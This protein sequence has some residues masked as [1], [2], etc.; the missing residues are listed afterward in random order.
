MEH[1]LSLAIFGIV[2]GSLIMASCGGGGGGS[3]ASAGGNVQTSRSGNY[4]QPIVLTTNR[5]IP[6]AC[7]DGVAILKVGNKEY[8]V[9]PIPQGNSSTNCLLDF[10]TIE[11]SSEKA[12]LRIEYQGYAPIEKVLNLKLENGIVKSDKGTL[13]IPLVGVAQGEVDADTLRSSS[14]RGFAIALTRTGK[15]KFYRGDRVYRALNDTQNT[16]TIVANEDPNATKVKYSLRK[17]DAKSEDLKV[18]PGEF[19]DTEGNT[20]RTGGFALTDLRDEKGNPLTLKTSRQNSTEC[21]W[22]VYMWLSSYDVSSIKKMKDEDPNLEGCQVPIYGWVPGSTGWEYLGYIT[23]VDKNG[24]KPAC[25]QLD[26]SADYKYEA[27]FC[28]NSPSLPSWCNIDQV[29]LEPGKKVCIKVTQNGKPLSIDGM[30]EAKN[31]FGYYPMPDYGTGIYQYP[32]DNPNSYNYYLRTGACELPIPKN[33]QENANECDYYTE[34]DIG[35]NLA[36]LTAAVNST[37]NREYEILLWDGCA[38]QIK[39]T[40]NHIAQFQVWKGKEISIGGWDRIELKKLVVNNSREV[41]YLNISNHSP[42]IYIHAPSKLKSNKAFKGQIWVYDPD[43]D[44]IEEIAVKLDGNIEDIQFKGSDSYKYAEFNLGNLTSG[45]HTLEVFA[46]DS[47]GKS[48]NKTVE[49]E[50]KENLPPK[51]SYVDIYQDKSGYIPEVKRVYKLK[52]GNFTVYTWAYDPDGEISQIRYSLSGGNCNENFHTAYCQL[53]TEGNYTLTIEVTDDEGAKDEKTLKLEVISGYP[54]KIEHIFIQNENTIFEA[55]KTYPTYVYVKDKDSERITLEVNPYSYSFNCGKVDKEFI[56]SGNLTIPE[57]VSG[58]IELT[59]KA[60]DE[61]GNSDISNYTLTIGEVNY[62]P[63]IVEFNAPANVKL[64]ETK[65]LKVV[66]Y[67]PDGD[68][69]TYKWYLDDEEIGN[70]PTINYTFNEEG[71]HSLEVEVS[72]GKVTVEREITVYVYRET[73]GQLKIKTGVPGQYVVIFDDNYNII[74]YA[75]TNA[76]GTATVDIDRDR[77]NI[78]VISSPEEVITKDEVWKEFMYE[79]FERLSMNATDLTDDDIRAINTALKE[80]KLPIGY[81]TNRSMNFQIGSLAELDLN[82]DGFVSKDEVY[83]KF[84]EQ[85]DKNSDNMVEKKE[86]EEDYHYFNI[87]GVMYVKATSFIDISENDEDYEYKIFKI[88]IDNINGTT[89]W[90]IKSDY[91]VL[92]TW[93]HS[94]DAQSRVYGILMVPK[95]DYYTLVVRNWENGKY[96]TLSGKEE[97]I[98]T[99]DYGE[100]FADPIEITINYPEN[101]NFVNWHVIIGDEEGQMW[102]FPTNNTVAYIPRIGNKN[103][104]LSMD[105]SSDYTLG[106]RYYPFNPDEE[107]SFDINELLSQVPEVDFSCDNGTILVNS[108]EQLSYIDTWMWIEYDN[109]ATNGTNVSINA[110]ILRPPTDSIDIANI[111]NLLNVDNLYD[112]YIKPNITNSTEIHGPYIGIEAGKIEGITGWD[113]AT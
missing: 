79:V 1:K 64:G 15:V 29:W 27:N 81:F 38:W 60:T 52:V 46:K 21:L 49:I 80:N 36:T 7:S 12:S 86:V 69:L 5:Q 87:Q 37:E 39:K 67:D 20:L 68:T 58:N 75:K 106:V 63:Q 71:Y 83:Q 82:D 34:Y 109:F 17:F 41:V 93:S 100:D 111:Q 76:E 91:N 66:A 19:V 78:A 101:I 70:S 43:M 6:I 99:L 32:L 113:D 45:N 22:N 35:S 98:Y 56:C 50:V 24:N 55:G 28:I 48:T 14:G 84:V 108:S 53:N 61:D 62:P 40:Q 57:G 2:G 47:L 42:R 10:G 30:V 33:F 31:N 94:N 88:V 72:D 112:N 103:Y 89:N 97:P 18:F 105:V 95:G 11:L 25:D 23:I 26:D 74:S 4:T 44:R 102:F 96:A 92:F 90:E 73:Q 77:V 9:I 110:D 104:Y 85:Y 51:I 13:E 59:F 16:L 107:T 54:P 65:E 3:S 8:K